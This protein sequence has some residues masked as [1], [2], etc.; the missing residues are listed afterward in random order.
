MSHFTDLELAFLQSQRLGRLATVN[1]AGEPHVIPL[2]FRYN[3]D[4]DTIDLFGMGMARSKKYR[5]VGRTGV[6]A[7]VVDDAEG[8]WRIR[9]VEVR[10]RA[11]LVT[12]GAKAINE[13]FDDEFIRLFPQ[14]I[15]GWGLD[16]DP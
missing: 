12:S 3:A 4:L 16:T 10:G 11:E 8:Q 13:R 14:R 7:F 1:A 6:A 15:V 2:T 9:G 5:D